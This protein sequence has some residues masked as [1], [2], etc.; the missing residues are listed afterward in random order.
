[1]TPIGGYFGLE[2]QEGPNKYHNTSLTFKTGRA[3]LHFILS[4]LKPDLVYIPFY[5]CGRILESFEM[6][7]VRYLFYAVDENLEPFNLPYLNNNEFFVYINYLDLKRP[8]VEKLSERYGNR[9]IVDCSQAFF[10]KGNG[11]SWFFNSCRKFF[12]VP[13]GSYLYT[14]S[15]QSPE[16]SGPANTKYEVTHLLKRFNGFVEE[17][18]PFYVESELRTGA[19]L[20]KMSR[21]TTCLLSWVDYEMVAEMRLSNYHRLHNAFWS[22]HLFRDASIGEGVPMMY[23][24]FPRMNINRKL[25]NE[26]KIFLPAFWEEVIERKGRGYE[27]ERS[28]SS[29]LLP[30]PV[31][32]RYTSVD[33]FRIINQLSSLL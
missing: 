1:M 15:D 30:L 2:L 27:W 18:Y 4:F 16:F 29:R 19:E 28:L 24:L 13:D 6:A 5:T 3:S 7:R 33:M 23:P 11:R 8:F 25:L 14:P 21:L 9:L 20:E 22:F 17:G 32:H 12:G 26:K 31:D 10:M